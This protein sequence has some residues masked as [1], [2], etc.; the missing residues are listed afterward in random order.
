V[1]HFWFVPVLLVAIAW[2]Y[3]LL[4]GVLM[5]L[6]LPIPFITMAFI[7][8]VSEGNQDVS[9]LVLAASVF[10]IGAAMHLVAWW[11]ERRSQHA[12]T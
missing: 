10:P 1:F 4:G 3:P 5:T 7:T 8:V 9:H 11:K 6:Y 12:S 2:R